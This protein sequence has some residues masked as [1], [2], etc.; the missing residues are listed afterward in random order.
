MRTPVR[1]AIIGVIAQLLL[2]GIRPRS[3]HWRTSRDHHRRQSADSSSIALVSAGPA[4]RR[5]G[6][7]SALE[8]ILSDNTNRVYKTQWK[9][10]DEWC[11]DIGLASLP[12]EPLTVARYLAARAG[13]GASLATLR[14]ATPPS[15]RPMSGRSRNRP[16]GTL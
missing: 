4:R 10:F 5:Q 3:P 11:S 15:P 12:V 16:V 8:S 6:V 1:R 2:S 9:L 7:A 14:L 13:S